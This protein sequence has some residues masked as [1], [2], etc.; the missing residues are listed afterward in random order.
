MNVR[1]IEF[2][3]IHILTPGIVIDINAFP[4][5]SFPKP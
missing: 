4:L 5:G 1:H 3:N 2:V